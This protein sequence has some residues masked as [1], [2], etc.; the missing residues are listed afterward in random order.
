M[1]MMILYNLVVN[2]R[3]MHA[4]LIVRT[5]LITAVEAL[6]PSHKQRKWI[7]VLSSFYDVTN[8]APLQINWVAA[9]RRRR[10][11]GGKM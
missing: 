1:M 2:P 11:A 9:R 7:S 10:K 6:F 4:R 8:T 5:C 3:N